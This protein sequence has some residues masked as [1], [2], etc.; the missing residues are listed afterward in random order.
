MKGKQPGSQHSQQQ[1]QAKSGLQNSVANTL[2][3]QH[4]NGAPGSTPGL[5]SA[6]FLS[7]MPRHASN[8][9]LRQ[10][11]LLQAQREQ[12]NGYV[13]RLV[14]GRALKT[15]YVTAVDQAADQ[16]SWAG[17]Q[18]PP[19]LQRTGPDTPTQ[20]RPTDAFFNR[21]GIESARANA[22]LR[23]GYAAAYVGASNRLIENTR[24]DLLRFADRYDTA[25][26]S[27]A[28]VVRAGRREAQNQEL[29]K[30]VII[31]AAASVAVG[32]LAALVLPAAVAGAATFSAAG[33][34]NLTGQAVAGSVLGTAVSDATTIAGTE[35]EP[36]GLTPSVL[37]LRIWQQLER[38]HQD[39]ERISEVRNELFLLNGAAEY[40]L[41]QIRL[42]VAGGET[43]MSEDDLLDLMVTL[44]GA[45]QRTAPLDQLREEATRV[46][47]MQNRA[48]LSDRYGV[49][50]MEQDIW[51]MWMASIPMGE[52]NILDLDAIENHLH[53]I[54]VLGSSSRLGVDFGWY[55]ST[56]D[57][58][59]AIRAAQGEAGSIQQQYEAGEAGD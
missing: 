16:L 18:S 44:V 8:H 30:G 45:D 17:A 57:E 32:V 56:A 10:R 21:Q 23:Y 37:Q 5:H 7:G 33:M 52:S 31:G 20:E 46:L 59:A 47:A 11:A 26:Q 29:V 42:H 24:S 4:E 54:G 28:S 13:Q 55:T 48:R 39:K 53:R 35:L 50:R 15:G 38:M 6:A 12:G 51:I 36:G 1:P 22:T 3:R 40:G 2:D 43:D 19:A 58:R 14:S 49:A 34:A 41:G 9:S 27:Y 25:Y